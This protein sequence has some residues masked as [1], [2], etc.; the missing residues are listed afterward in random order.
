MAAL[1]FEAGHVYCVMKPNRHDAVVWVTACDSRP[2]VLQPIISKYY[3]A[4]SFLVNR[5]NDSVKCVV[6]MFKYCL[7]KTS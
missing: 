1:E 2:E 6:N 5:S 7:K 3:S 4:V